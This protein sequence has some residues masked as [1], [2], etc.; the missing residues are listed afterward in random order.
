MGDPMPQG[1]TSIGEA[2]NIAL[3]LT[4]IARHWVA[5]KTSGSTVS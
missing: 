2:V 4:R 5:P 3:I 1:L